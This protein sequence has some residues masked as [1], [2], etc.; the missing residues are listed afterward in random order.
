[1]TPGIT[2][3]ANKAPTEIDSKSPIITN[4]IDGGINIPKVPAEAIVPTARWVSYFLSN[5]DGR[6]IIVSITTEAPTIPVVAAIIVPIIVTDIAKPPGIRLSKTCKQ[7]SK[8]SATPLFS[9]MVPI[10][11]N[12]GTATN[13][14][15]EAAVPHMRGNKL[16]NCIGSKTSSKI[17]TPPNNIP[18][19][20]KTKA[21][22]NP[23]NNDRA[24]TKKS[25]KE[26]YSVNHAII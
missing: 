10:K 16:K 22:G 24:R 20:P 26:M 13:I 4:M 7:C 15:F 5:I 25:I 2:A 3:A 12:M 19:P 21:T 9:S 14:G 8:S 17:P 18:I 6:A 11:I 1:M 23:Q